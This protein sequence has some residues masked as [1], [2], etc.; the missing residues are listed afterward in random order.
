MEVLRS[1]S[2][3]CTACPL[4]L[5]L[6]SRALQ[7]GLLSPAELLSCLTSPSHDSAPCYR[8][9]TYVQCLTLPSNI[10]LGCRT[11]SWGLC[12]ETALHQEGTHLFAETRE[13][14]YRLPHQASTCPHCRLGFAGC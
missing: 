2:A 14:K 7:H 4:L 8:C 9:H 13:D 1:I 10:S 12:T 5:Q 6:C 11:V 3:V